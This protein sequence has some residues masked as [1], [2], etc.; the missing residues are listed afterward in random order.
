MKWL[1]VVALFLASSA[2]APSAGK[3]GGPGVREAMAVKAPTEAQR[4]KAGTERQEDLK[5]KAKA[6]CATGCRYGK[7]RNNP[8][9]CYEPREGQ[10]YFDCQDAK[11]HIRRIEKVNTPW[12]RDKKNSPE[13]KKK[14]E[15]KE[16]NVKKKAG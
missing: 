5:T 6:Q 14:E 2:L 8:G 9:K 10:T 4:K 12:G 3:D 11:Y 13:D 7:D 15:K 1:S 16:E